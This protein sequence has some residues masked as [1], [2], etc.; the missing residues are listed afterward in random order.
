MPRELKEQ[1]VQQDGGAVVGR[2][3]G[4][5]V[6]AGQVE[7]ALRAVERIGLLLLMLAIKESLQ[8]FELRGSSL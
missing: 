1:S 8:G 7:E 6:W 2:P 4:L 3:E 5:G